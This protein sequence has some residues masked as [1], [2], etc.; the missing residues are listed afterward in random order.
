MKKL[1]NG[2]F[3]DHQVVASL[4]MSHSH[5]EDLVH[6][7][8]EVCRLAE[9]LLHFGLVREAAFVVLVDHL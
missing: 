4:H 8:H 1:Q 5:D 9:G 3:M 6:S 2:Y 7:P